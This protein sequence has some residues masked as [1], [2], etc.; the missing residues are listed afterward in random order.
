MSRFISYFDRNIHWSN[1]WLSWELFSCTKIN[2]IYSSTTIYQNKVLRSTRVSIKKWRTS[3][4]KH[5]FK[6]Y[7]NIL[8]NILKYLIILIYYII[9]Y[10]TRITYLSQ[11]YLHF[12]TI[13]YLSILRVKLTL[14]FLD[15][16]DYSIGS[17]FS[18]NRTLRETMLRGIFLPIAIR[19]A[20]ITLNN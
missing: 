9:I 8:P 7:K 18:R 6:I 16:W 17:E 13:R 20:I 15:V 5:E 3:E 14:C 2:S 11:P 1:Y 10:F 4:K 12:S 19:T